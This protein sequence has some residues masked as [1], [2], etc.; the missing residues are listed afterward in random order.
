MRQVSTDLL[1]D[2]QGVG[3]SLFVYCGR[4]GNHGINAV[5]VITS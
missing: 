5:R 3:K 1:K 4:Y 2:G